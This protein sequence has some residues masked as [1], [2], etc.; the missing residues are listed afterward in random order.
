[1]RKIH[2]LTFVSMDG[3]MQAPGGPEEDKSGGFPHGGW[4]VG[5]FDEVVGPR[6]DKGNGPQLRPP[7]RAQDL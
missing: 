4:T 5:Y 1:M 7:A 6:D 3:V 2:V